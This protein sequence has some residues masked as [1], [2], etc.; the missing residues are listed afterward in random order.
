MPSM[1]LVYFPT[2]MVDVFMGFHVGKYTVRPMDAMGY[3]H[4]DSRQ[5]TVGNDVA[6]FG[7]S[8]T[9]PKREEWE[10]QL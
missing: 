7:A 4:L 6:A 1:Q 8:N 5:D 9:W 3:Q 2:W 10:L